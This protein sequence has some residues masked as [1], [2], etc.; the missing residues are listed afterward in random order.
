M[1]DATVRD[2]GRTYGGL[3]AIT[4]WTTETKKKY[5]HTVTPLAIAERDGRTILKAE[6]AG[7]F[8][9]SPITVG[10]SFALRDGRI[11]SLEIG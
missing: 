6:L 10:F 7:E 1:A 5:R 3:A 8:P 11:A 2:E 9:G 4:E